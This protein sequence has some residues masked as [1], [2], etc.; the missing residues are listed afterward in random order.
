[1]N[2]N[3]APK[4]PQDAPEI[5][6]EEEFKALSVSRLVRKHSAQ[7]IHAL[8]AKLGIRVSGISNTGIVSSIKELLNN[9]SKRADPSYERF[10]SSAA[11]PL[12]DP[13]VA[14]YGIRC[15][16]CG[17]VCVELQPGFDPRRPTNILGVPIKF[18][19]WPLRFL[20]PESVDPTELASR[21]R[22]QPACAFCERPVAIEGSGARVLPRAI[23]VLGKPLEEESEAQ[24]QATAK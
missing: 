7:T 1:M 10:L 24:K 6:L 19:L 12:I 11:N 2:Q 15:V 14:H 5:S 18:H 13:T 20:G 4:A 21:N 3:I 8:G 23:V 17:E 9:A 22:E 16:Y